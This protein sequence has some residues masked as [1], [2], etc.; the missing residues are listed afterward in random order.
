MLSG[1]IDEMTSGS[2][3]C[4]HW[5]FREDDVEVMLKLRMLVF[6]VRGPGFQKRKA[7]ASVVLVNSVLFIY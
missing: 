2:V 5:V 7:Y 1:G 6:S 4:V 3:V